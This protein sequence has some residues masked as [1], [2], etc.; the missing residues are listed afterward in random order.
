MEH[1]VADSKAQDT[2][3]ARD[4]L[5]PTSDTGISTS[6]LQPEKAQKPLASWTGPKRK[7][8]NQVA[9]SVD[10]PDEDSSSS[11]S[12]YAT[13]FS[14]FSHPTLFEKLAS[15]TLLGGD[16]QDDSPATTAASSDEP[17]DQQADEQDEST[18]PPWGNEFWR[19]YGNKVRMFGT[20]EGVAR[21]G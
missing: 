21:F 1:H 5:S 19:T 9:K 20:V 18:M 10:K 11:K 14:R 15:L 3:L 16:G 7:K 13:A 8:K 2:K 12:S 6:D 17:A 4:S